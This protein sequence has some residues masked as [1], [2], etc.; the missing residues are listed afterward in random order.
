MSDLEEVSDE[1][2]LS[3]SEGEIELS[4]NESEQSSEQED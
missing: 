1:E 3:Q 4:A 2:L